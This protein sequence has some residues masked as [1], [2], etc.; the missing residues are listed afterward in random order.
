MDRQTDKRNNWCGHHLFATHI[1]SRQTSMQASSTLLLQQ[2]VQ[3]VTLGSGVWS[4][5]ADIHWTVMLL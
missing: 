1:C 3:C 4:W 5:R 2:Y